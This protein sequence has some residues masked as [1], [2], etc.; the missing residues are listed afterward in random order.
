ME[1]PIGQRCVMYAT[2]RS[3][4]L[5][6][7]SRTTREKFMP[8]TW[9]WRPSVPRPQVC[10]G[11]FVFF[12]FIKPSAPNLLFLYL[13]DFYFSV[14]NSSRPNTSSSSA[15]EETWW[16]FKQHVV[17]GRRQQQQQQQQP[18]PFLLHL[19]G[20]V[21]QP[22]HGPAAL[23]GQEA[24]ETDDQ[25]ETDGD[26]RPVHNTRS[27]PPTRDTQTSRPG[28]RTSLLSKKKKKSHFLRQQPPR[29]RATHAPSA[30]LN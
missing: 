9:D 19:P 6:W 7:P 21:Q 27:D 1:T 8:R 22:T 4:L 16:R 2:W 18:R 5:W 12:L 23:C 30:T 15:E 20:L 24:Q 29:W 13:N 17:D 3:P 11:F 10:A 14:T 26:V 25:A 28:Q